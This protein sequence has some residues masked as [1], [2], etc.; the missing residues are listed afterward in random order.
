MTR[1]PEEHPAPELFQLIA[2]YTYD[3]ETW[4]DGEGRPRWINPAVQRITGYTVQEC[5][6]MPDYPLPLVHGA[7]RP[8]LESVLADAARGGSGNDVEFRVLRKDGGERWVAISWQT[9]RSASGVVLGYRTSVRDIDERK[10]MEQEL[11][12]MR[13]RAEAAVVARSELLANVSHELRS[14]A[15]CIAGFAE[16]LLESSL[17]DTQRRHVEIIAAQCGAM[18][19]QV[20]D[21]LQL[22]AIE[23]GGLRLER[24]GVDLEALVQTLVDAAE[25]VARER[26]LALRCEIEAAQRWVEA[27]GTRFSQVLRNLIDNAL[28]FTPRGEVCVRLRVDEA[29]AGLCRVKA[30]VKD[31]GIGMEPEA[32]ERLLAPF[33]QA[34]SGVTRRHGGVGLGLAIVQR[35]LRRMGSTLDIESQ[36][37]VGTLASFVVYLP[38]AAP[39]GGASIPPPSAPVRTGRALIVDDS[40]PA[41][42][43]LRAML[44]RLG[45]QVAEA[46]SGATARALAAREGFDLVLLDYQ[47]PDA[48]GAETALALRKLF[49]ARDPQR[50][51]H[52]YLLTANLFVHEQLGELAALDGIL[53]KPLS[54]AALLNL[55]KG[56]GAAAERPAPPAELDPE[57]IADLRALVSR[58]GS[59]ML[60]RIAPKVR[61]DQARALAAL[62]EAI[63]KQDLEQVRRAAHQIAGHASLVGAR[64]V[65]DLARALEDAAEHGSPATDELEASLS[66]LRTAWQHAEEALEA[67]LSSQHL[68]SSQS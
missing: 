8:M 51:V 6:G 18:L 15:H 35:L 46:S 14:P 21:L 11:Q 66:A 47:M 42:E 13:K 34:D 56:L 68:T 55:L 67:L 50:A 48:D 9:V 36:P 5:L 65:T 53:A 16:L 64:R 25:P 3:W 19:R 61:G 28:K 57:V 10:R 58:D 33:Q 31:T 4:V 62:A 43:L 23:A 41:R 29:E 38:P 22:A 49:S 12:V 52:M 2:E 17:D 59:D 37:G 32:I 26:G 20:E 24:E 63:D 1:A 44:E 45:W 40:G 7:D 60:S 54:R 30:E 27:D 39:K